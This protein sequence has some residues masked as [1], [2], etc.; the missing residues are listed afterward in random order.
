MCKLSPNII[1]QVHGHIYSKVSQNV[2]A[3]SSKNVADS[4]KTWYTVFQINLLLSI[5]HIFHLI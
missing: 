3:I 4:N 1:I 2:I 5:V